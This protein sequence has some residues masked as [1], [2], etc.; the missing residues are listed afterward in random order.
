MKTRKSSLPPRTTR[1]ARSTAPKPRRRLSRLTLE[2]TDV[3]VERLN[4]ISELDC[5]AE[6]GVPH[7]SLGDD[8]CPRFRALWDSIN[9]KRGYGWDVNPWCWAISFAKVSP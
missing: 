2:I 4:Q 3:R 7:H 8:A 5:E 1:L 9:A 6:L